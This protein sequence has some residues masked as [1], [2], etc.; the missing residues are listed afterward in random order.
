MRRTPE[1]VEYADANDLVIVTV[2]TDFSM[3]IA[4]RRASSPSVV[5]LRGV[6]ELAPDQHAALVIADLRRKVPV[7]NP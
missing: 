5:L 7:S 6:N 3:L 1:T 4:L 2:D